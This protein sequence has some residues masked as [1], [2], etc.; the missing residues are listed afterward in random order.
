MPCF[1]R[2]HLSS[3]CQRFFVLWVVSVLVFVRSPGTNFIYDEQEAL[4][5]SQFLLPDTPFWRVFEFD[6]WG[7]PPGRTIGSYRPF[8]NLAYKGLAFSLSWHTPWFLSGLNLLAH[9]TVAWLLGS[10]VRQELHDR[11][12]CLRDGASWGASLC[13]CCAAICTEAVCSVVGL[14]DVMMA[15]WVVVA[16]RVVQRVTQRALVPQ[17]LEPECLGAQ[18]LGP[19]SRAIVGSLLILTPLCSLA[20]WSKETAVAGA[21]ILPAAA[22]LFAFRWSRWKRVSLM[23]SA[24]AAS[25]AGAA[26][27]RQV[28]L[29]AYPTRSEPAHRWVLE[30][31]G[32]G[33][34]FSALEL[35]PLPT[36]AMN[37]PLLE[38]ASSVRLATAGRLFLEQLSQMLV[39]VHLVGD[40][41]FPAQALATGPTSILGASLLLFLLLGALFAAT[42]NSARSSGARLGALGLVV[43]LGGYAPIAQVVTLLPMIRAE[44]LLYLPMVGL[45]WLGTAIMV[46][47]HSRWGTRRVDSVSPGSS[48]SWGSPSSWR[49]A[50]VPLLVTAFVS[51]QAV[52]A[53]VSALRYQDDVAFWRA[54]S[55]A[56]PS[57]AKSHL[58]YGLMLG[59]RGKEAARLHETRRAVELAPEWP[60]GRLYLADAH[61]RRKELAQAAPHYFWALARIPQSQAL[62]ALALQC[63]HDQGAYSKMRPELRRLA[64]L[65]PGS[66]LDYLIYELEENGD[67]NDGLPQK[68]RPRGYNVRVSAHAMGE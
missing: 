10:V 23:S 37:N 22:W 64:A 26:L 68:Y 4:L 17:S 28:R 49:S 43:V 19:Q 18:C 66:W 54:T 39:P 14:A 15:G 52:R 47:L 16:I 24:L 27:A 40:Y 60:M 9:A 59:A 1:A 41:S 67:A 25:I 45:V 7:R 6:F 31:P 3:S 55:L 50:L 56:Q 38:E 63:I 57:S 62:T 65:H 8:V 13:F 2:L 51:A 33:W 44:R 21:L 36:D 35:P 5:G 46:A 61:C 29:L 34:L 42:W 11:P 32:L 30:L 53:R 48:A 58:N 12:A 20:W